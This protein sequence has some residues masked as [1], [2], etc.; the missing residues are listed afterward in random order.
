MGNGT[1][2]WRAAEGAR[3]EVTMPLAVMRVG[4]VRIRQPVRT[5][6]E[7]KGPLAAWHESYGDRRAKQQR[8]QQHCAGQRAS[9]ST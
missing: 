4:R 1:G 3:L 2:R 5:D 9:D 7:G 8:Q 6:L